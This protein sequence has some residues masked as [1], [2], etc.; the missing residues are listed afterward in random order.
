M[1]PRRKQREK[2]AHA[3]LWAIIIVLAGFGLVGYGCYQGLMSLI[4]DWC[5]D[6]PSVQDTDAFDLPEQSTIY[7]NDGT[8]V[9]AEM[10]MEK[11]EPVTIDQVSPYVLKGT[12]ATEDERFYQHGGV[13][14]QGILRAVAVNLAGGQEG[15]STITQQHVRNTILSSE[16]N[17][18]SI[19]RKVREMTLAN[20]T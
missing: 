6:L 16:M 15:A 1:K 11:R 17:D 18:I 3:G 2:R 9:L 19:K 7:A 12:V 14:L 10:Y 13:D 20:E 4:D 5:S 8:T